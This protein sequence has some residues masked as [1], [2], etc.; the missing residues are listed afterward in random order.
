VFLTPRL[1]FAW[2]YRMTLAYLTRLPFPL[3]AP[4]GTSSPARLRDHDVTI[5]ITRA[6]EDIGDYLTYMTDGDGLPIANYPT[7]PRA[8]CTSP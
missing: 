6:G 3:S 5:R 2:P 7:A 1:G 8:R 4:I